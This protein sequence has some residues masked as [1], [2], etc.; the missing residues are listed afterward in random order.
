MAKITILR[1]DG[2]GADDAM[3]YCTWDSMRL[4]DLCRECSRV[5]LQ[6]FFGALDGPSAQVWREWIGL[7]MPAET[8]GAEG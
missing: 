5:A 4:F 2:C 3:E 7:G 8:D 6:R 1:C